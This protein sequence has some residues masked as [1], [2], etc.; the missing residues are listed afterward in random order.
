MYGLGM[1]LFFGVWPV[2][3][4]RALSWPHVFFLFHVGFHLQPK[5]P[6][7]RSNAD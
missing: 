5:G 7:T 6:V 4:Q 2:I 3:Q 1:Q